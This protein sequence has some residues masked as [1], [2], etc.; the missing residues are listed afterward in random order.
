[1]SWGVSPPPPESTSTY[2]HLCSSYATWPELGI[3]ELLIY[4]GD[5]DWNPGL[6]GKRRWRIQMQAMTSHFIDIY[7]ITKTNSRFSDFH[8]SLTQKLAFRNV[9]GLI[10]YSQHLLDWMTPGRTTPLY[11]EPSCP[12]FPLLQGHSPSVLSVPSLSPPPGATS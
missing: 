11:R 10:R 5:S 9:S 4:S 8:V 6:C 12:L 7:C 2:A 1:M 3:T